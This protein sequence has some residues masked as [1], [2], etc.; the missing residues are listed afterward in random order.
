MQDKHHINKNSS[1]AF[2]QPLLSFSSA[3]KS[4]E[5]LIIPLDPDKFLILLIKWIICQYISFHQVKSKQF[6]NLI[7]YCSPVLESILSQ[8]GD[9]IHNWILKE[10]YKYQKNLTNSF[11]SFTE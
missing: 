7:T 3:V 1:I 11:S 5:S 6:C 8:S 2:K 10:F 9:T 4:S